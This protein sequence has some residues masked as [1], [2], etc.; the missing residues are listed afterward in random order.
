MANAQAV[1]YNVWYGVEAQL[2]GKLRR[3]FQ[4]L[5]SLPSQSY[6]PSLH[7]SL[8]QRRAK[9]RLNSP[10]LL[11]SVTQQTSSGLTFDQIAKAI[12]KD[13][14]WVAAAFYGQVRRFHFDHLWNHQSYSLHNVQAKMSPDDISAL[15]KV[16][17]INEGEIH[18]TV[19][20][21]WFPNRTLGTAIPSDPVVYRLY[22][23]GCQHIPS[24]ALSNEVRFRV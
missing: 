22:E 4:Q 16:L 1:R 20:A 14:V 10:C 13:E 11:T 24:S 6:R 19:G 23:V 17:E 8:R 3:P 18:A 15:A 12:G 21:H 2:I 5:A 7:N 9:V